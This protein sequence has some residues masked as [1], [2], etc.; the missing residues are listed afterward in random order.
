MNLFPMKTLDELL[1]LI[2]SGSLN[3][4]NLVKKLT[5]LIN[6]TEKIFVAGHNGMVGSAICRALERK[7]YE[8]IIKVSR[9]DL[10]L[11]NEIEVQKWFYKNKQSI[12]PQG[13]GLHFTPGRLSLIH[14]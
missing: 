8:S 7:G 3:S 10:D 14:I 11:R 4:P 5:T 6:Y 1:L 2:G 9:K 12:I 13:V